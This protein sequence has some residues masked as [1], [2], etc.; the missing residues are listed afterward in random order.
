MG[1][2]YGRLGETQV[3]SPEELSR[4]AWHWSG[5]QN[6]LQSRVPAQPSP[7]VCATGNVKVSRVTESDHSGCSSG[8][9]HLASH[10]VSVII[11][12]NRGETSCHSLS[13]EPLELKSYT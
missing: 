1:R 6:Y 4:Q 11:I 13:G 7:A 10:V 2:L 3:E 8:A 9:G 5:A 12:S